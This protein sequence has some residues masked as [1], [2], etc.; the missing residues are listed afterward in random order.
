MVQDYNKETGYKMPLTLIAVLFGAGFGGLVPALWAWYL[1]ASRAYR[2]A[3][4]LLV[5]GLGYFF[6]VGISVGSLLLMFRA[7]D[8]LGV[9]R[10]SSQHYAALYSYT[11]S[12]AGSM[13]FCVRS[14][15]RWRRSIGLHDK[16]LLP[17]RR[18]E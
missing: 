4:N 11:A 9:A 1:M 13:Y 5:F 10:H 2:R 6:L 14:E 18:K 16:T 12:L 8:G 3:R 17:T 15:I 7:V